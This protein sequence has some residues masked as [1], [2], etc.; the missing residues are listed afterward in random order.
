MIPG[1]AR[2]ATLLHSCCC[3]VQLTAEAAAVP[4]DRAHSTFLVPSRQLDSKQAPARIL[5][6]TPP[7][8]VTCII[9]N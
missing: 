9:T 8:G 2:A 1:A 7:C 5:L 4:E 3:A 6:Y